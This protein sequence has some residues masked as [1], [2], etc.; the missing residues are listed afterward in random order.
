MYVGP[1]VE[2]QDGPVQSH[3]H[4]AGHQ[5]ADG[6]CWI[7]SYIGVTTDI[8]LRFGFFEKAE[9]EA[10]AGSLQLFGFSYIRIDT[11]VCTHVA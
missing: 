4:L 2:G 1:T 3:S 8:R 7:E 6:G 11:T 10:E 5:F 9:A